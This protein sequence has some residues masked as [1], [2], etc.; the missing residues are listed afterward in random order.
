MYSSSIFKSEIYKFDTQLSIVPSYPGRTK[1]LH[2]GTAATHPEQV[3]LNMSAIFS[4]IA[5]HS[6]LEVRA[7]YPGLCMRQN[8]DKWQCSK[9][10]TFLASSVE[11]SSAST[12]DS[13]NLIW[14][15]PNFRYQVVFIGLM[16]VFSPAF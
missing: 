13:L 12:V 14:I 2:N 9:S 8:P 15:A 6:S 7:G 16:Y 1:T 10:A 4:S 3:N 5:N 11:K